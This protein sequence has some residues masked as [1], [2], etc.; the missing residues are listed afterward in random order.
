MGDEYC[1]AH[2]SFGDIYGI[3][4]L[5]ESIMEEISEAKAYHIYYLASDCAARRG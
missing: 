1:D 3:V 5:Y 2:W 4:A